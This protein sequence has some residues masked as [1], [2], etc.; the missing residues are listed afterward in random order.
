M[1]YTSGAGDGTGFFLIVEGW[2]GGKAGSVGGYKR[3]AELNN[4]IRNET[5]KI[6]NC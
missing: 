6:K 1:E 3:L 4:C 2:A 5:N